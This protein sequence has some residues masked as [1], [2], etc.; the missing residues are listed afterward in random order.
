MYTRRSIRGTYGAAESVAQSC[1]FRYKSKHN[2]T[3][4]CIPGNVRQITHQAYNIHFIFLQP[5]INTS[6]QLPNLRP[7]SNTPFHL[8]LQP[9]LSKIQNDLSH[10]HCQS[11][12]LIIIIEKRSVEVW[13]C[14]CSLRSFPVTSLCCD[15]RRRV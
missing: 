3:R 5:I 1:I 15:S 7:P 12:Q 13:C 4:L 11:T 6:K 14:S 9:L 8:L 10:F 2:D